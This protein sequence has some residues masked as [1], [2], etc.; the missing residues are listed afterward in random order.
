MQD[1]KWK[2]DVALHEF[3]RIR[4]REVEEKVVEHFG[5]VFKVFF[6]G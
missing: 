1:L 5:G 3:I 2:L 4:T 6:S